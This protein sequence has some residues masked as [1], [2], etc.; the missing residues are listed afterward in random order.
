MKDARFLDSIRASADFL[1]PG[2]IETNRYENEITDLVRRKSIAL[3]RIQHVPATGQPTRYFE[4]TAIAQGAFQTTQN[5]LSPTPATP[6]RVERSAVIKAIANQTNI[7]LFDR[8]VTRQQGQFA[9]IIAQDVEDVIN[10]VVV[11]SAAALWNGTDTSLVTPTTAQYVGLLTQ[12]TQTSVLVSGTSIIDGLKAQVATMMTNTTFDVRPSAIYVNPIL[13][14]LIDQEAKANHFQLNETE[15]V[16]GVKVLS[17]QT[18]AGKLPIIPDPYLPS[19]TGS[20]FGFSAPPAGQTNYFAVITTED[21]LKIFYV[22][23][24]TQNPKPRL[25]ELGLVGNLNG[26][27]VSVLFDAPV[28]KGP[29]YAH[30][31]VCVQH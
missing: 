13:A 9:S 14:D 5:A 15:V 28:A 30:A 10:G 4:Q 24:E 6:T 16:A 18:Q 7:T 25:F 1:G 31:V 22:S 19:S 12:I 3:E 27:F 8:D 17:I 11:V 23:G 26:Q 21:M 20:A 2:A 29:S